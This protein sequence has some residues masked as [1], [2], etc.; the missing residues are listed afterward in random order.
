MTLRDTE[1]LPLNALRFQTDRPVRSEEFDGIGSNLNYLF[2]LA[3][4]EDLPGGDNPHAGHDHGVQGGPTLPLW[5]GVE[6]G[7]PSFPYCHG[8]MSRIPFTRMH[9]SA[10]TSHY[11]RVDGP[12]VNLVASS[13]ASTLWRVWL[14]G[15]VSDK[16]SAGSYLTFE[17]G[18]NN[19]RYLIKRLVYEAD[20]QATEITLWDALDQV[21]SQ[22]V[23]VHFHSQRGSADLRLFV[24][25]WAGTLS[26]LF[27][28]SA[29][30][31]N[32][33]DNGEAYWSP[34]MS[35]DNS[36]AFRVRLRGPDIQGPWCPIWAGADRTPSNQVLRLELGALARG[37]ITRFEIELEAN[38]SLGMTTPIILD[39]NDF[40]LWF[41]AGQTWGRPGFWAI[42][43]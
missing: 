37:V 28:A 9:S 11:L 30:L 16:A 8:G 14:A 3:T 34:T 32:S 40:A 31:S 2:K 24:P 10:D 1:F 43:T 42:F 25:S 13:P 4:G 7:S 5:Y 27:P 6:L 41:Q 15:D 21:P 35:G 33:W 20:K 19:G 39:S 36:W 22:G 38:F 26:V 17:D 29:T 18:Q 23:V 12:P